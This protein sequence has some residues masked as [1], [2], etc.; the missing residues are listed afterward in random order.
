MTVS[1]NQLHDL[2]DVVD[3]SE[4]TILYHLLKKFIPEETPAPDEIE[5]IREGRESLKQGEYTKHE[6]IN[7]N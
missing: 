1:R 4:Y 5:A 3:T 6:D 7:W 2:I